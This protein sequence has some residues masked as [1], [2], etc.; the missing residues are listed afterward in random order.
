MRT[1]ISLCLHCC[2]HAFSV[3][4]KRRS[5]VRYA[6]RVGFRNAHSGTARLIYWQ[7]LTV[8]G[9]FGMF[10]ADAMRNSLFQVQI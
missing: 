9:S 4:L 6:V 10:E 8:G 5:H 2:F 7:T 3:V 1:T